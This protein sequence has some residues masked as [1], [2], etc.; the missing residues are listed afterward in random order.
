MEIYMTTQVQYIHAQSALNDAANSAHLCYWLPKQEVAFHDASMRD[1]LARAAK[2]L[3][4]T[5]S[6]IPAEN[7][8]PLAN[9]EQVLTGE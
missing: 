8:A 9:L 4:Y 2:H 6:P 7:V 5:L 3:G 1:A